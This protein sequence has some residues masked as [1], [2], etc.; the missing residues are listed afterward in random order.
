MPYFTFAST[1]SDPATALSIG[2]TMKNRSTTEAPSTK[3]RLLALLFMPGMILIGGFS[4]YWLW[5]DILP[6][7][8]RIYRN[9]PIVETPYLG[10]CL[11]MV[12]PAALLGVLV[13]G[14]VA[15]KGVK[16]DPSPESKLYRFQNL[17]LTL[18]VRTMTYIVPALMILT[19]LTLLARG[20]SPCSKLLIS[21]SAWQVFWVN[22]ENFCFKPSRYIND[23]WPCKVIG[24][25]EV[26]IQVDGR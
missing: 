11:L 22:N 25:E 21:G 9:A 12:P 14:I 19:T 17:M 18:S 16:L 7:Y 20:Y 13:A 2:I 23:H 15:W 6:L 24:D 8:G 26:C 10:F 3:V 1:A 4:L 5:S